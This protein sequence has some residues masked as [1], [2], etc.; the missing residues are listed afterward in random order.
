M[1]RRR[2]SKA[3]SDS[4]PLRARSARD[5]AKSSKSGPTLMGRVAALEREREALRDELQ[6][7]QARVRQLES[8]HAQVRDRIAWALD[9]LRSILDGKD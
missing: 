2:A 9:S 3:R 8:G 4:A 6:R 7:T 5:K 1:A